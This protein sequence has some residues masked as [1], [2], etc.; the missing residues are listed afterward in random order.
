VTDSLRLASDE[1]ST[2]HGRVPHIYYFFN[3]EVST[4]C[5]ITSRLI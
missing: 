1:K 2:V 3:K 4:S 5:V